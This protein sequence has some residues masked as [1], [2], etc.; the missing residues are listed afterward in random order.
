[1]KYLKINKTARIATYGNPEAKNVWV[2][3][4]GYGQLVP[5]F[6]RHFHGL[7]AQNN[8]VI[9]PEG[10]HRFYLEGTSGRV[11][12]SWMTKEERLQDIDD[13]IGY[14]DQVYQEMI[15]KES[16]KILLG[17]SQGVAT[18]SRWL[19]LSKSEFDVTINWAG[20][21]PPDLDF[22]EVRKMEK[23]LNYYVYGKQDPYF[24][25]ERFEAFKNLFKELK[26]DVTLFPFEGKHEINKSILTKIE[27]EIED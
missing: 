18:A 14:L 5:F 26:I 6:I 2:V 16:K 11:G 21:F 3:L 23:T 13:Y 7:S 8:Y 12:A 10:F 4:H 25:V 20:V 1:M 19:N 15:P 24:S 9:A 27:K 22:K 17:F